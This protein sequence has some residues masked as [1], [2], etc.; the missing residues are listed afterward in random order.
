MDADPRRWTNFR[1][2]FLSVLPIPQS[3]PHPYPCTNPNLL[4]IRRLIQTSMG[5]SFVIGGRL[6]LVSFAGD[7]V[8]KFL[9]L[10]FDQMHRVHFKDRSQ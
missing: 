7:A 2:S 9:R 5:D 4:S 3:R 8:S 6:R 1:S 10:L